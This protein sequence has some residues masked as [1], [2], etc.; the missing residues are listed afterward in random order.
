VPE[1][2]FFDG[3][4]PEVA[5]A[6]RQAA[7]LIGEL[8]AMLVNVRVPDPAPVT[9]VAT[10]TTWCESSAVH[11]RLVRERPHELGPVVRAR[12]QHGFRISALD[13]LQATR[14]RASLARLFI[15]EVFAQVDVLLTPTVPEPAPLLARVKAAGEDEIAALT[16]RFSRLTRPFNG[17]GLPALSVPGG[18]SRTGLPLALQVAGRP[19]DEST[20]L[21]VGHAY[22]QAA[23]WWSRRPPG[24]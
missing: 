2:Y 13:Y 6:V 16:G 21:R 12:L 17:L 23:G 3:V 11:A 18:F 22:E 19:F 5:A 9:D 8:G 7:A 20:V 24:F 10:I 15:R 1:N 4:D 14:L